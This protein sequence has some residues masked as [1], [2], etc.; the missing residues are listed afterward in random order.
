MNRMHLIALM[1][2]LSALLAGAAQAQAVYRIVGPDG[3]VTFSDR[4]PEEIPKGA[5]VSTHDGEQ[6]GKDLHATDALPYKLRQA[7]TRY[8]VVLYTGKDCNPCVSGRNLLVNRGIPFAERTITSNEDIEALQRLAGETSLP[9][10]TVGSQ[11]IK[12]FSDTEWSQYLD[13]AGY[14]KTSELPANY[15]RPAAAPLVVRSTPVV[16]SNIVPKPEPLPQQPASTAPA[17]PAPGTPTPTN[18][19][20]IVF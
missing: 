12:G 3:R 1:T 2:G 4:A 19:A 14:P 11:R 15:Q 8:P 9:V 6:T 10:V 20:G 5:R 17:E 7:A 18:P 16:P 13:A